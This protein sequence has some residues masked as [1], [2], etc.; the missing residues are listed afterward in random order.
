MELAVDRTCVV[1]ALKVSFTSV[2]RHINASLMS[3]GSVSR[4]SFLM[5]DMD[6]TPYGG[7][8]DIFTN[9]TRSTTIKFEKT[10]G[11]P[12]TTICL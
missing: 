2:V 5:K 11:S 6:M 4:R 12:E 10:L 8:S 9:K 3:M 7:K 1:K